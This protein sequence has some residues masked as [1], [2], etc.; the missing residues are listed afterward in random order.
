MEILIGSCSTAHTDHIVLT[1]HTARIDPITL[2]DGE[3]SSV[4]KLDARVYSL[5][6]VQRTNYKFAAKVCAVVSYCGDTADQLAIEFDPLPRFKGD[7]EQVKRD[8]LIELNDQLLRRQ[9]RQET[10]DIRNI[11]LSHAF[12]KVPRS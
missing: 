9:V 7:L 8:Y 5:D 1:V 3:M 2:V 4:L 10:E 11:I 12:S 6:D